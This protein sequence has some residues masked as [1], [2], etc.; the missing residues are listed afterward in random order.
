MNPVDF[1]KTPTD[2]LLASRGRI[3]HIVNPTVRRISPIFL[4]LTAGLLLGPVVAARAQTYDLSWNVIAGGGGTSTG[5]NY[6]VSGTIGQAAAGHLSGGSYTIDGGFWGIFAVVQ[7][8]GAPLLT[9]YPSGANVVLSWVAPST[10]FNLQKNSN[11]STTNWNPVGLAT[12]V[13]GGSNTVTV[14]ATSGNLYFRLK[15]P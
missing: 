11:L 13:V 3:C 1:M 10:G 6:S 5:S 8:P 14:P 4:S 12:N 2:N 9:I 15:N 7:T